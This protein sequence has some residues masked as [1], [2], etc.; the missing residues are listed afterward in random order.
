LQESNKDNLHSRTVKAQ[1]HNNMGPMRMV[2]L[3]AM[4]QFLSSCAISGSHSGE[5]EDSSGM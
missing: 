4:E 5:Y 1:R 2:Q 3:E